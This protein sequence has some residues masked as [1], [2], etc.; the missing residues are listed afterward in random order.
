MPFTLT[1][2]TMV[3]FTTVSLTM[4]RVQSVDDKAVFVL[5][6]DANAHHSE[7]FPVRNIFHF[8]ED[9]IHFSC[10]V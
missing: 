7:W 9:Y 10:D 4:A 2:S 1:Q 8:D 6:G 3:H 5:A